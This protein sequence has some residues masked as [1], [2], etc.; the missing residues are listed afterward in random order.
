[1]I[2]QIEVKEVLNR[3]VEVEAES[4][5]EALAKVEESYNNEEIVL[6][7]NDCVEGASFDII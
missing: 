3:I 4:R 6:D 2:Y 5:D 1:M 7:S